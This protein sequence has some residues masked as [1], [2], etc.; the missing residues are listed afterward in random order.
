MGPVIISHFPKHI[1]ETM[2]HSLQ[3]AEIGTGRRGERKVVGTLKPTYSVASRGTES[4]TVTGAP[5]EIHGMRGR[6]GR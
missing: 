1:W 4:A 2:E 3:R 6:K 5:E